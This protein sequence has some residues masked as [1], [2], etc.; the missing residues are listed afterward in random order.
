MPRSANDW[1]DYYNVPL[2]NDEIAMCPACGVEYEDRDADDE[3]EYECVRCGLVGYD[4]C[5]PGNNSI[6][7]DCEGLEEDTE[8]EDEIY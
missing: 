4:C 2:D 6:C 8:E 5:V 1:E 7:N 3:P